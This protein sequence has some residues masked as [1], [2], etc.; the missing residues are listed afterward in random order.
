M[1][2]NIV[3]VKIKK[4]IAKADNGSVFII[5]DFLNLAGYDAVRKALSR[6]TIENVLIRVMRG[7]YKKPNYNE[8]IHDEVPASPDAIARAIARNNNWTI[9]P[10]DDVAL[11]ILGLTTQVPNVYKYI[12]NGSNMEVDYLG[13]KIVFSKRSNKDVSG[14]SYKTILIIEALR[15]LGSERID[16]NIR[17]K[18][19]QKCTKSDFELLNKEG[20]RSRKWIYEE[21]KKIMIL[22]GYKYA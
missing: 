17:I 12:S 8:F 2:R 20:I 15:T 19:A 10:K 13:T 22:G 1:K 21:I 3:I 14:Y 18:I 16:D 11:N 6:L 5:A 4:R 7:M 9:G